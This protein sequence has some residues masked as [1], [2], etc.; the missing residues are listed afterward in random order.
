MKALFFLR[1]YNDIDH[2]TPVIS[3][4]ID[5]GHTCDIVLIGNSRFRDDYRIKFL[6]GL[7]GVRMAYIADV[8]PPVE[9]IR[10]FFQT[11]I[12]IRSLRRPFI[13]PIMNALASFYDARRRE[14][15]W[16]STAKRLLTRS[17]GDNDE[18][19][20]VFD[21]IER[22]SSICVEWVKVM[23]STARE[24]G[25]GTVSLPHGDSPHASQL[26]RRRELRLE[27]DTTF[28]NAGIFERVVVPNELCSVRFRPFMD[29]QKLAVLGSPRY[30]DEWLAKLAEL[31]PPSPL[32]RSDSKL[33]VVMFLRKSNFSTFWEEVGEVVRIVAGFPGVELVIKPHTRGGWQQSLT[34]DVSLRRLSN[35]S[36]A[37]GDVHSI[38]LMNWADV[39][40][41]LATSVVFEA[42][43][44]KKPV[45]AADYLHAGRSALAEFMP[46]TE[47]RCRDDVYKN[48]ERFLSHGCDSFYIEEHHQRFLRE[49][50]DVGGP[51]VLSR[52][53][54]LLEGQV[55]PEAS[56]YQAHPHDS[57]AK[58]AFA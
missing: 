42:V 22:N 46:E 17:F 1:H 51:D 8:L 5:S 37:G 45:L 50:I 29:N 26:I 44:T 30:C 54:A 34:K 58:L 25:L 38:Y 7:N 43:K 55:R 18:G 4:W 28:A 36:V 39:I 24:M 12:L 23:L 9:F 21:W 6:Q 13:G 10:W 14:P 3:K 41:D 53:V 48:I 2:I 20:V 19:V 57:A 35:V 49:M 47:L 40:I 15:I 31:M 32:T 16:R 11:L 52:Y 33:K 56:Q 27:P